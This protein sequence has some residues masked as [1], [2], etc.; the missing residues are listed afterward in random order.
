[1]AERWLA[2]TREQLTAVKDTDL[3]SARAAQAQRWQGRFADLLDEDPDAETDLQALVEEIRV[4]LPA[5]VVSAAD[6][7]TPIPWASSRKVAGSR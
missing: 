4:A 1:V 7:G 2:A 6:H 5:G 3:D